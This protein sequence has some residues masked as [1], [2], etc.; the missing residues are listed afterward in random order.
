[1]TDDGVSWFDDPKPTAPQAD[2]PKAQAVT[3]TPQSTATPRAHR[4]PRRSKEERRRLRQERKETGGTPEH[5]DAS[6]AP[7]TAI[8]EL[9][10]QE[11]AILEVCCNAEHYTKT[12]V[13]KAELAKVSEY[14]WRKTLRDPWFANV[15]STR[16][17][18]ALS[19]NLP[20][21]MQSAIDSAMEKGRDGHHDRRMLFTMAGMGGST[22]VNHTGTV[23][24]EHHA[25]R[26]T[27][28]L[29]NAE[30]ATAK[31]QTIDAEYTRLPE[32]DGPDF[33]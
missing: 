7:A 13:E 3:T 21:L 23:T 17:L 16:V 1:M 24:H 20:R 30:Q 15:V 29:V 33:P 32:P 9:T 27:E 28:A 19:E 10:S 14:A 5:A 18:T 8:R 2:K 22:T 26:L 31:A 12:Q 6:G 25:D 4:K 11:T